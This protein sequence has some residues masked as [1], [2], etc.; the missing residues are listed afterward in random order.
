MLVCGLL[1][2]S[3]L[4]AF[5]ARFAQMRDTKL[6][7]QTREGTTPRPPNMGPPPSPGGTNPWSGARF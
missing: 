4:L 1:L 7:R 2:Y 5:L 3:G 6:T